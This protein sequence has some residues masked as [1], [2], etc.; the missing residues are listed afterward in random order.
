MEQAQAEALVRR[1]RELDSA[2]AE[3]RAEQADIKQ[4]VL[5]ATEAGW[6]LVVDGKAAS[7]RPAN[8]TFSMVEAI[9]RLSADDKRECVVTQYDPKLIRAKAEAAGLL[10]DC[11]V[12]AEDAPSIVSL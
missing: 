4:T 6:K 5:A 8:R 12:R 1:H 10:D 7:H 2:I 11:M 9:L 3:L